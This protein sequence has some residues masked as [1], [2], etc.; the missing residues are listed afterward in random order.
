M[1]HCTA[2][3]VLKI[4]FKVYQYSHIMLHCAA[5]SVLRIGFKVY[6]Y[7]HIML[8]CTAIAVI[9]NWFQGI[10]LFPYYATLCCNS[11]N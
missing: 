11:C 1:L 5:I 6:Q 10:P 2:I 4:G 3:S 7:S 8:H 9:E